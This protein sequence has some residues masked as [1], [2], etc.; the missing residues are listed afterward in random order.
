MTAA[1]EQYTPA[2][3][4]EYVG[5]EADWTPRH[6]RGG[7]QKG[8]VAVRVRI[9]DARVR[10]GTIDLEIEPVAGAGSVWVTEGQLRG[11]PTGGGG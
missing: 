10:Y 3:L 6:G 7:G 2:R 8:G 9:V 4:A 11:L 1:T 5:R